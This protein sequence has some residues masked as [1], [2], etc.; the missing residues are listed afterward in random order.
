MLPGPVRGGNAVKVQG[1]LDSRLT[2]NEEFPA[3]RSP[4]RN[5]EILVLILIEISPDNAGVGPVQIGY[6][7]ADLRVR[8]PGLRIPGLMKLAVLS[9]WRIN[10]EHRHLRIV[11]TVEADFSGIRGPPEGTVIRRPAEHF[12]EINPGGIAV[13]DEL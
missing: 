9:E 7:D 12:L 4:E 13:E 10:R 2:G 6:S 1:I 5:A 11:I 8:F 3:V